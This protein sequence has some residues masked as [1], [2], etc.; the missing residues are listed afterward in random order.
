[1]QAGEVL[2][3]EGD[4]SYDF[5]VVESGEAAIVRGYGDENR[6]IAIPARTG[7]WGS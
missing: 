5:F 4:A 2:F 3:Q 1:V 6:V 7:S